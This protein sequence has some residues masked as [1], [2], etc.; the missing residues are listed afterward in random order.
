L[1]AQEVYGIIPEATNRPQ[2]ESQQFWSMNYDT[3]IPV[4]IKAIQ[5]LAAQVNN[6]NPTGNSSSTDDNTLTSS[7]STPYQIK[8]YNSSDYVGYN[9]SPPVVVNGEAVV[10]KLSVFG[11]SE[12][13]GNIMVGGEALFHGIITVEGEANFKSKVTFEKDA[14]FQNHLSVDS[15]T[16]STT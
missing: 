8:V 9:P 4:M 13:N 6:P 14:V 7:T 12:F 10:M 1:I 2:D 11:G 3:L 16:A 5:E 15:D